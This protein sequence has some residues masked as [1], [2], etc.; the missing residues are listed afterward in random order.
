MST[1]GEAPGT[2]P[3]GPSQWR[4]ALIYG[5]VVSA[6][7]PQV[8]RPVPTGFGNESQGRRCSPTTYAAV[9]LFI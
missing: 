2:Y 8:R 4:A 3:S 5:W 6:P 7:P 1:A 9:I